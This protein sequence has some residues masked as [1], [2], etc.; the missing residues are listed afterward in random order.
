M[1][2]FVKESTSY[3]SYSRNLTSDQRKTRYGE[4]GLA[5]RLSDIIE[6]NISTFRDSSGRKGI[7]LETAGITG[8]MSEFS[9]TIYD[10][11]KDYNTKI[12]DLSRLLSDKETKYYEKFARLE[13]AISQMNSQSSWLSSQLGQGQ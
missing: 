5:F 11:I 3:S 9:N 2:L 4:E 1:N 12:S 10:Q 6:D 13:R 7:L 8:D